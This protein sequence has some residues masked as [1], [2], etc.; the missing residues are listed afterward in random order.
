MQVAVA[1][2]GYFHA[3]QQAAAEVQDIP[4]SRSLTRS[5]RLS[6][7]LPHALSASSSVDAAVR[8]LAVTTATVEL[9]FESG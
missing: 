5:G 2:H 6:H 3:S 1:V 8:T 9:Y 4:S 7:T